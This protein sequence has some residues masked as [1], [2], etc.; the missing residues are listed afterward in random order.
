MKQVRILHIGKTGGTAIRAAI[1]PHIKN[2]KSR[3]DIAMLSHGFDIVRASVEFPCADLIF[4]VRDPVKRFVSGF[5]S[6]LRMGRPRYNS[7]WSAAENRAFSRFN[8]VNSLGEAL[9]AELQKDRDDAI[10]AIMSISHTR[11]GYLHY[12]KSIYMLEKLSPRIIF[13]GRQEY[14]DS[15]VDSAKSL[16]GIEDDIVL[17]T[18]DVGAHRTPRNHQNKLSFVA[19]RNLSKYLHEEYEIYNWCLNNREK[20]F[21]R[22]KRNNQKAN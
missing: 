12:L 19:H 6:R 2:G 10:K 13:I 22:A 18:D 5:N 16:L 9:S 21:K 8:K 4:F 7:P 3:H 1:R 14:L 20:I 15:D 11:R 17:P